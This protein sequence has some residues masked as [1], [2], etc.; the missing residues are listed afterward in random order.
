MFEI[1]KASW[2]RFFFTFILLGLVALLVLIVGVDFFERHLDIYQR[3]AIVVSTILIIVVSFPAVKRK[4]LKHYAREFREAYRLYVQL[5]TFTF[6]QQ[7]R[8]FFQDELNRQ[9]TYPIYQV[10]NPWDYDFSELRSSTFLKS[11]HG[12]LGAVRIQQLKLELRGV[13]ISSDALL[14]L[15]DILWKWT[16]AVLIISNAWLSVGVLCFG[17]LVWLQVSFASSFVN[18]DAAGHSSKS[19]AAI[20]QNY[21]DLPGRS[22]IF[23]NL[24][25]EERHLYTYEPDAETKELLGNL[26][27]SV[28]KFSQEQLEFYDFHITN[29]DAS[30]ISLGKE[31]Y[32]IEVLKQFLKKTL[33]EFQDRLSYSEFDGSADFEGNVVLFFLTV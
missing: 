29:G 6:E 26:M 24:L 7:K 25:D 31:G 8:D 23:F 14:S 33:F 30:G 32:S 9:K 12:T 11:W 1:K 16:F 22:V 20:D 27:R 28:R 2:T 4:Q 5:A 17:S 15:I 19:D 18:A 3:L 21:D 10:V 13:S